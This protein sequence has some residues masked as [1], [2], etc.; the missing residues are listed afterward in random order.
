V[1][2]ARGDRY[3]EIYCG[4]TGRGNARCHCP[5]VLTRSLPDDLE[6]KVLLGQDRVVPVMEQHW[7]E[8]SR[9]LH[10]TVLVLMM[11]IATVAN[12]TEDPDPFH[13]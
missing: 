12:L 13:G 4:A 11:T 10:S 9:K 8:A 7:L 1:R 5:F 6:R 2:I 3:S